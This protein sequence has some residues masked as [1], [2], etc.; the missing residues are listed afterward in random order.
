MQWRDR[1]R[2]LPGPQA[3]E[4]TFAEPQAGRLSEVGGPSCAS[5]L[6]GAGRLKSRQQGAK[7]ASADCRA[8]PGAGG[9]DPG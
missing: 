8:A 2:R 1:G 5:Y 3:V 4:T 6:A 7:S 9:G